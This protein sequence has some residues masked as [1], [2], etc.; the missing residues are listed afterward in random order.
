MVTKE[1]RVRENQEERETEKKR[2]R[3]IVHHSLIQ[4]CLEHGVLIC[5]WQVNKGKCACSPLYI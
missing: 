4:C 3:D 2:F 5:G 1:K